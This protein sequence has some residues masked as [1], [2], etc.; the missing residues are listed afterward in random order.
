MAGMNFNDINGGAKK[1]SVDYMKL[2]DGMNTFRILPRTITPS[3]KYWVKGANGKDMPFECLAFDP[4]TE[5]FNRGAPDPVRDAGVKDHKGEDIKCG[6]SYVCQVIEKSSGDIKVLQLK[7]GMLQDI[8]SAAKQLGMDPTDLDEGCWITVNRKKTGPLAYNV[9]YEVQQLLMKP[10]ALSDEEKAKVAEAKPIDEIF[11]R[12][13]YDAQ[14]ERL[15]KHLLGDNEN[16][17]NAGEQDN[18]AINELD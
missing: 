2:V 16:Q 5:T 4:E 10:S 1:N 18:E 12:E 8:I 9:K 7:K 3:Y 6:W 11:E 17:D 13:T 14:A 15:R